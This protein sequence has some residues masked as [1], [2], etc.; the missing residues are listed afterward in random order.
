MEIRV[1]TGADAEGIAR[2]HERGWRVGYA[3]VFPEEKL[4]NRF[5]DPERWRER[6]EEPP[7][8][9]TTFVADRDGWIAGFASVGPSRE[10]DGVGELYAIYVDPE[11]WGEG[12]GQALI[13]RAEEQLAG[14]GY[15][16]ATLWVLEDNPRAHRFYEAAGWA[17]DGAR[18]LDEHLDMLV[19]EVRYRK[20]ALGLAQPPREEDDRQIRP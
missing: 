9:W 11:A 7:Q 12:V 2:V 15:L 10:E 13:R 6:L 14:G 19:P 4:T 3:H 5:V 16:Q 20:H 18:K 1:A 17:R 8:G